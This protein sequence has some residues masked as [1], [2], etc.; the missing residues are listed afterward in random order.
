MQESWCAGSGFN[1]L[2]HPGDRIGG[3]IIQDFK[4]KEFA[5]CISKYELY[6]ARSSVPFYS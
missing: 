4:I 1:T 3:D 6:E 2:L 5:E